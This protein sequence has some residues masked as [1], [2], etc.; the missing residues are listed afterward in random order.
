M[1]I[2]Q[3]QAGI[4]KTKDEFRQSAL[5]SFCLNLKYYKFIKSTIF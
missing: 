2:K 1:L 3:F 5:Q 4:I